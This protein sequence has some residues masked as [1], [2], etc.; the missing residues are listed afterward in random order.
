MT[1]SPKMLS[2]LGLPVC[3]CFQNSQQLISTGL[4]IENKKKYDGL[5]SPDFVKTNS[6][7]KVCEA[8]KERYGYPSPE[9]KLCSLEG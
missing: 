8:K 6:V 2:V 4:Y 7:M 9:E 5:K 1:V 3:F